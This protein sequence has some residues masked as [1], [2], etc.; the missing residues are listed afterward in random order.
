MRV[1]LGSLWAYR[2]RM[3]CMMCIVAGLMLSLFDPNGPIN[4][5]YTFLLVILRVQ[6]GP[7]GA[8]RTNNGAARGGGRGEG[9]GKPPLRELVFKGLE[10]LL[11]SRCIYTPRGTRPR[12]I[13]LIFAKDFAC[14]GSP[15]DSS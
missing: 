7:E 10:G 9:E 3:A 15:E 13:I 6:E 11:L 4:R 5:K 2:R 14:Q 1:T 12:R 8:N